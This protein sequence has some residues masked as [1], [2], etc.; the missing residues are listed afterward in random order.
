MNY[1]TNSAFLWPVT[2]SIKGL[3]PHFTFATYMMPSDMTFR[4]R[5]EAARYRKNQPLFIVGKKG[6]GKTHLL[7]S[8]IHDEANIDETTRVAYFDVNSESSTGYLNSIRVAGRSDVLAIDNVEG[9]DRDVI[10]MI[11][12]RIFKGKRTIISVDE[13]SSLIGLGLSDLLSKRT[14]LEL[15]K[16][17][18]KLEP[19]ISSAKA[20]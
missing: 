4:F 11:R 14:T 2:K 13:K 8:I 15:S 16:T 7:Q 5:L 12:E 10:T 3:N 19:Q 17:E 1:K 6:S 9:A 20:C 18:L